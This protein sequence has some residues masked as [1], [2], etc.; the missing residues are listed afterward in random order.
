MQ[1]VDHCHSFSKRFTRVLNLNEKSTPSLRACWHFLLRFIQA[2]R[3][4][5]ELQC[6]TDFQNWRNWASRVGWK[7]FC[8]PCFMFRKENNFIY[9]EWGTEICLQWDGWGEMETLVTKWV[10]QAQLSGVNGIMSIASWWIPQYTEQFQ[11]SFK[12]HAYS[13]MPAFFFI[14]SFW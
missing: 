3:P 9:A 10:T 11:K 4:T 2:R 6:S 1:H 13:S 14:Y 5:A 12:S 8:I 7:T